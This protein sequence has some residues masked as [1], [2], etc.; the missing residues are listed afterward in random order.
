MPLKYWSFAVML[1]TT[2]CVSP[3]ID[4]E[5]LNEATP[6]IPAIEFVDDTR[7]L[8]LQSQLRR[9]KV[10]GV[11]F[12]TIATG[13]SITLSSAGVADKTNGNP[14]ATNMSLQAASVSKAVTAIGVMILVDEKAIDLDAD[15][16]SYLTTWT[17]PRS[18]ASADAQITARALLSHSAGASVASFPG[19]EWN[20]DLPDTT[21]ILIGAEKSYSQPVTIDGLP[22]TYRYSGGGYMILQK[23]IEDVSG[24]SFE[25]FMQ[26]KVFDP[27]GMHD[28]TF[29]VRKKASG[30]AFGHTWAGERRTDPWQ[31]YPQS[32]PAGLWTTPDD[33]AKLMVVF[34]RAYRG[35]SEAFLSSSA[36]QEM[37]KVVVGET[38]LGFGIHGTGPDLRMSHG[39]WSHGYRSYLIFFPE[40]GEGL[41]AIANGDSGHNLIDDIL[42]TVAE[43]RGWVGL[44]ERNVKKLAIWSH[45]RLDA[46]VGKYVM[47]PAGFSVEISAK[48]DRY[49]LATPRGSAY[50]IMPTGDYELTI[51]QTG[52]VI[53]ID[54]DNSDLHFWGMVGSKSTQE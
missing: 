40:S 20:S 5:W 27:V 32:A 52:E 50:T 43:E 29:S 33:L 1:S 35:E 41:V 31:D 36:A 51:E 37:V 47:S 10:P 53:R 15:I 12:A 24:K 3:T 22:G 11:S 44:S 45:E 30:A 19:F 48:E 42:R 7:N 4:R 8:S 16:D 18:A 9:H 26:E 28:S 25:Q 17:I 34:G 39:G 38:G 21:E 49:I 46:L 14:L 2:S 6:L 54:P 23:V 13:G